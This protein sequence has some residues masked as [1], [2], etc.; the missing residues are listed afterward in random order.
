MVASAWITDWQLALRRAAARPRHALAI[1]L[2]LALGIGASTTVYSAL[3]T[4][5]LRPLPFPDDQ[6]L[7]AL[8][9]TYP[10]LNIADS[11]NTVADYLD[12]RNHVTALSDS[13]LY[14][15]TSLD[16]ADPA[17]GSALRVSA[18][19]A[20]PSLFTTLA[21]HPQLGRTFVDDDAIAETDTGGMWVKG[22]PVAIISDRFWRSTL[23]SDPNILGRTLSFSGRRYEV[24]GVM[25]PQFA[26]PSPEVQV[27]LPFAFSNRQK[28]DAMRGFEFAHSIGRLA[29]GSS[30]GQLQAQ[31]V[32]LAQQNL[33]RAQA[34]SGP[35]LAAFW[36]RAEHS[37]FTGSAQPLRD[38]LV[39]DLRQT[40]ALLMAAVV[41]L[42]A[43]AAANAAN[44]M[45]LHLSPHYRSMGVRQILGASNW[46]IVRPIVLESVS[47]ALAAGIAG[48]ALAG[49]GMA[50]MRALGLGGE[51]LGLALEIN[52]AVLG[53][54]ALAV[55]VS[56]LCCVVAAVLHW[57]LNGIRVQASESSKALLGSRRAHAVR[58]QFVVLQIALAIALLATAGL[59]AQS[60][61]QIQRVAPGF[62]AAGVL[63][64][65]VNLSPDRYPDAAQTRQF[66]RQLLDALRSLPGVESVGLL[67]S[68]PFTSD[69]DSTTVIRDGADAPTV[70]AYLQSVDA[71]LFRT[72]QIPMVSGRTFLPTEDE[73]APAVAV[74]DVALA[75]ALFGDRSPL[76]QRVA[77][78]GV[79]GPVWYDIVGVAGSIKR[80][81]LSEQA[82]ANTLYLSAVQSPPRIFR[83]VIRTKLPV[84]RVFG[85]VRSQM[86]RLDA[87][88]PIW[89]L[90]PL[91]QRIAESLQMRH[92]V[93]LI[94]ALFAGSALLLCATGLFST[95]AMT[96]A[97][98]TGEIG[99]RLAVGASPARIFRMVLGEATRTAGIG[100]LFGA[101]LALVPAPLIRSNLF[102]VSAHVPVVVLVVSGAGMILV[103]LASIVP[104]RRA[105]SVNPLHA[106]GD[107]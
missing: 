10:R 42:L 74:I 24:I 50:V 82:A 53:F 47:L 25:A 12:R 32:A 106:L 99:L 73:R 97:E 28:S 56:T 14:Y 98:R 39:G 64:L 29:E 11:G 54:A 17:V 9:N 36:Q 33:Q 26:F 1:I 61:R 3:E 81:D 35:A 63:G 77:T 30:I 16:L 93:L 7:V 18:V 86:Q 43:I 51:V 46:D 101:S 15:D 102:G 5:L 87:A 89:G 45:V 41:V 78:P 60:L 80:H 70:P 49:L 48:L 90:M 21:V 85:P 84:D 2:V 62:S 40:V 65:N 66:Q 55:T 13:A 96:I 94:V 22:R 103:L 67:S 38:K 59:L 104:A 76:A 27:W 20:S 75:K 68:L 79:N 100:V 105:A 92:A 6:Q 4:L 58:T 69:D 52:A 31:L 37:Q 34:D 71:D 107:H 83:I 88:Q 19:V 23:G 44:M 95:L 57:R 91:D 72:L 8:Y